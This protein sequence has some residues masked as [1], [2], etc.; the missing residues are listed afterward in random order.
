[1]A[2]T[3]PA[4]CYALARRFNGKSPNDQQAAAAKTLAAIK[5]NPALYETFRL[6]AE[7]QA[8]LEIIYDE[9]HRS[10]YGEKH[11]IVAVP[12]PKVIMGNSK[13]VQRAASCVYDTIFLGGKALGNLFGKELPVIAE[14]ER[15]IANGHS[16]NA[17]LCEQLSPLVAKQKTVRQCVTAK[18]IE[19][20]WTRI[21]EGAAAA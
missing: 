14:T 9:R 7:L 13:I 4:E 16:M 3:Y 10:T 2:T 21:K 19:A 15:A 6:A 17:E 11:R 18:R 1:M 20:I 8:C 5:A 12:A